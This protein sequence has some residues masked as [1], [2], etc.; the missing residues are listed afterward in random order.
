MAGCI[1]EA[2]AQEVLVSAYK[3]AHHLLREMNERDRNMKIME[4]VAQAEREARAK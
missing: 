4:L 3:Q 2:I 1:T